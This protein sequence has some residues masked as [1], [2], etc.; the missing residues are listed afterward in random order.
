MTFSMPVERHDIHFRASDGFPLQGT[1]FQGEGTGPLALIS[2]AAAVPRTIYARFAEHLVGVEGFRAVMTYDYRGVAKS[3]KPVDWKK[4]LLMRHWA[5]EDMPAAQ[6]RLNE[7]APGHPMVGVGQ[8][9]GGQAL[10]LCAEPE[11]FQRYLMVSVMSGHWRYTNEPIKVFASM[12]LVGVPLALATGRVPG[13]IGLGE[14]LPG[15]VFREWTRWGR[16]AEYFFADTTMNA[17][18]D[19]ARIKIPILA[20]GSTDDPWG[21]PRA[22]QAILRHYVNAPVE[23]AWVTPEQAKGPIG[24][25][26]FFRSNFKDTLWQPAIQ[27][28]KGSPQHQAL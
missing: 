4:P 26:G 27:W 20:I 25:L 3:Q 5:T 19:F 28:L 10:G 18:T 12:N 9:F 16:S 8:S 13:W 24:H 14:T 15:S 2:S 17:T 7:V 1:L 6:T 23:T 22:Q 21:T 11:R